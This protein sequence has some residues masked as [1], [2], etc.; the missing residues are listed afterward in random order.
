[1]LLHFRY[2]PDTNVLM[3]LLFISFLTLSW[4]WN[5]DSIFFKYDSKGYNF[6]SS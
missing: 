2:K 3:K 6:T 4:R 1:M 5:R